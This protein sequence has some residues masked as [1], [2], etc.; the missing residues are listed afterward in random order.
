MTKQLADLPRYLLRTIY[1]SK[2][3][4]IKLIYYQKILK[5]LF[6]LS[7]E[8]RFYVLLHLVYCCRK[9]NLVNFYKS[10]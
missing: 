1:I 9:T 2:V 10:S 8:Q 6:R 5:T 4:S 7:A 3:P